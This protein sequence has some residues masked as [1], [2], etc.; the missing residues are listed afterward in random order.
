MSPLFSCQYSDGCWVE[1]GSGGPP[2][3]AIGAGPGGFGLTGLLVQ[4]ASASGH[5]GYIETSASN[6]D[7]VIGGASSQILV[8]TIGNQP[9]VQS[10]STQPIAVQQNGG[11]PGTLS[12]S[13]LELLDSGNSI[14]ASFGWTGSYTH[15]YDN[16]GGYDAVT[17]APGGALTLM[18]GGQEPVAVGGTLTV[19]TSISTG[20]NIQTYGVGAGFQG[21]DRSS[22]GAFTIYR[23]AGTNYLYDQAGGNVLAWQAGVQVGAPAGSDEGSGTLNLAGAL[24]NNGTAPT[25]TG[26][27][28]RATSPTL[29]TPVL[30]AATATTINGN[31]FTAGTYT[32]TGAAGKTLTFNNSLTFAG[33][34]GA[35]YTGPTTSK[36]LMASDF[37]NATASVAS[38]SQ[39]TNPTGTTSTTGIMMGLAGSITPTV[40]GKIMLVIS[41]D[42]FNASAVADGAKVQASYGTGTAPSNGATITGTQCGARPQYVASTTAGKSPFSVNCVVTGLSLSTAY[43]LDLTLAAITGG[44]AT[45]ND[46]SISAY[47]IR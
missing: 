6:G 42:I 44:T 40:S 26:A 28:V 10:S 38:Q 15:L 16:I 3:P 25:G 24:Y 45:I 22:S 35:T 17:L 20:G 41:G 32:V 39:P 19:G 23:N 30:G 46:V 31:T 12:M 9:Y 11:V 1:N 47:E 37:S 8:G 43:W 14:K 7:L 29:T 34:D 13:G 33:T 5:I 21:L 27:Y 2:N 36:T 18:P 4:S